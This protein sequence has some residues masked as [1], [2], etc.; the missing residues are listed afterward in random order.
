M[1]ATTKVSPCP[2]RFSL[3]SI[4]VIWTFPSASVD[5]G[6]AGRNDCWAPGCIRAMAVCGEE[7]GG[8]LFTGG[9]FTIERSAGADCVCF[10]GEMRCQTPTPANATTAI[11]AAPTYARARPSRPQMR[12]NARLRW[13]VS[14]DKMWAP[15]FALLS[16]DSKAE[17]C[18]SLCRRCEGVEARRRGFN[19]AADTADTTEASDMEAPR[20]LERQAA[21]GRADSNEEVCRRASLLVRCSQD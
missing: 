10:N 19:D 17:R 1:V 7:L 15:H 3:C 21:R 11:A 13:F 20:N 12:R 4:L 18:S 14:P 9:A 5:A 2:P 16:L 8:G 6:A